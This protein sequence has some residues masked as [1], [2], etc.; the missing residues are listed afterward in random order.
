MQAANQEIAFLS[1]FALCSCG[2]LP[3]ENVKGLS[4]HIYSYLRH[5]GSRSSPLAQRDFRRLLPKFNCFS[6]FKWNMFVVTAPNYKDKVFWQEF[7]WKMWKHGRKSHPWQFW[8]WWITWDSVTEASNA[9]SCASYSAVG[10]WI[11]HLFLHQTPAVVFSHILKHNMRRGWSAQCHLSPCRCWVRNNCSF[12][13]T[14]GALLFL[15]M[16]QWRE[17][18]WERQKRWQG[19]GSKLW[20]H[21]LS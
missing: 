13:T 9:L 3:N 11:F 20:T 18:R 16:W 19:Q 14:K 17:K 10:R 6:E 2:M 5:E 1:P 7:L 15:P 21:E 12:W 4:S 8:S